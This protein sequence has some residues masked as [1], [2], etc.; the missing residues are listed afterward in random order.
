M[1]KSNPNNLKAGQRLWWVFGY[2]GEKYSKFVTVEKVGLKWAY[3]IT[4]YGRMVSL[5]TMRVY[6]SSG[7]NDGKCYL[8]EAAY[9]D[10]ELAIKMLAEFRKDLNDFSRPVTP[11]IEQIK[12]ARE[13][14]GL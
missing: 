4:K 6:T 12:K 11:T 10:E 7:Y 8:N 5:A 9:Q 14:L 2:D 13:V 1:S 3:L